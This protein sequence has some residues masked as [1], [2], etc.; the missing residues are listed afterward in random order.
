MAYHVAPAIRALEEVR[1]TAGTQLAVDTVAV[2]ISK[3]QASLGVKA[4]QVPNFFTTIYRGVSYTA[5]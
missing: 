4:K 5:S 1:E 2:T 3:T